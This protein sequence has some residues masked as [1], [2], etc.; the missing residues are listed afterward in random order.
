MKSIAKEMNLHVRNDATWERVVFAEVLVPEVANVYGDY[1][2]REGIKQAAYM[3][4][5]K[6]Y[7]IDVEHNNIDVTGLCAVVVESFI[8]RP[9]DLDFIEGS[10]VV[11]MKILDDTL[12]AGVLSGEI[13]GYSYEALVEFFS[14]FITMV[15]DGI[16]QGVTEPDLTDG[17]THEFFVLVDET[18]RPIDGGTTVNDGHSH[19]ISVHTTTDESAGHVHRYN[20][21]QGKD[22]K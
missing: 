5:M 1:W 20:L 9:G 12:W 13:N 10:W 7:G 15:D 3:F 22:G 16:R 18:N 11:G 4:M 6:G 17:H 2:T 21:V 8:V 19:T 14:G